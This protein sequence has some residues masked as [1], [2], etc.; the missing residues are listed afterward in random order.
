MK[1]LLRITALTLALAGGAHA[2]SPAPRVG[3]G[4]A[5]RNVYAFQGLER[6]LE[7]ALAKGDAESLKGLVAPNVAFASASGAAPVDPS[8]R[9]LRRRPPA[10]ILDLAV[11]EQPDAAVVSFTLDFRTKEG[12]AAPVYSI[13]DTWRGQPRRLERRQAEEMTQKPPFERKPTGID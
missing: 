6:Q 12:G 10:R 7:D 3:G 8:A 4:L 1:P 11:R 5:T 13:V 9:P 2:G